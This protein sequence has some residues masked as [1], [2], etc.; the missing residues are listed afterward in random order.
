[1]TIDN[2]DFFKQY[3]GGEG[4]VDFP[5][6]WKIY[7]SDDLV[8][9]LRKVD[10]SEETQVIGTHYSVS[11]VGAPTGGLVTMV[12]AP[13]AN[14]KL[15]VRL[16]PYLLQQIKY[17]SLDPFPASSHELGLDREVNL[18]KHLRELVS[19][20][21]LFGVT[22]GLRNKFLP[23]PEAGYALGWDNSE[24]E[25]TNLPTTFITVPQIDHLGNYG[26]SLATAVAII[27]AAKVLL[28]VNQATTVP[29]DLIV[30]G[31]LELWPTTGGMI[32]VN[33]GV[34]LTIHNM[35]AGAYQVFNCLGAGKVV[36]GS[37]LIG[38][39]R[40]EW[41]GFSQSASAANNTTAFHKMLDAFTSVTTTPQVFLSP[42]SYNINELT[43]DT[44]GLQVNGAGYRNPVFN[45]AGTGSAITIINAN[46]VQLRNFELALSNTGSV[47]VEIGGNSDYFLLYLLWIE[48]PNGATSSAKGLRLNQLDE[49]SLWGG[50]NRCTIYKSYYGVYFEEGTTKANNL[51]ITE[52][53]IRATTYPIHDANQTTGVKVDGTSLANFSK[54]GIYTDGCGWYGEA[55]RFGDVGEWDVFNDPPDITTRNPILLGPNAQRNTFLGNH[56]VPVQSGRLFAEVPP[57]GEQTGGDNIHLVAQD[58]FRASLR[59]YGANRFKSTKTST[60]PVTI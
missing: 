27:G 8:V 3:Q 39:A 41:W 20:A 46:W 15:N 16:A 9:T 11:G 51:A 34:T 53:A 13:T 5:Y 47:G 12:T 45:Y 14:E 48:H 2:E 22:E 36:F 7:G 1:M 28:M 30:P 42:G 19:R 60:V 57:T 29:A 58:G 31:N 40:P 21:P 4:Q 6:T 54:T 52:C 55:N 50:L 44:P 26:N 43:I 37:G 33:D 32:T 35:I 49:N 18:S 10:G 38:I 24:T 23:R 25:L 56:Y 17:E 59:H